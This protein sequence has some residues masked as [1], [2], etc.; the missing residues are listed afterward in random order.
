MKKIGRND[1]CH[2]G[3]GKKFKKCCESKMIGKRFM[4]SKIDTQ[5]LIQ[6]SAGL[7]SLFQRAVP[8]PSKD[9]KK[10]EGSLEN[11]SFKVKQKAGETNNLADNKT[12]E[13]IL[14]EEK[15]ILIHPPKNDSHSNDSSKKE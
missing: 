8:L 13:K 6:K 3:S 12:D 11:H 9:N 1:P 10:I 14:R 15:D 5:S 4:A 7:S 2:C